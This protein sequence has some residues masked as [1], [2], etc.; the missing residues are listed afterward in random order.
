MNS[1]PIPTCNRILL[2][3]AP[4]ADSGLLLQLVARLA[5]PRAVWVMVPAG[6][7]TDAV[8]ARLSDLLQDGDELFITQS[9]LVLEQVI[10]KYLFNTG[11]SDEEK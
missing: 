3:A 1:F 8:I 11:K 6:E 5:P 4:S 10:G 2:V 9:A 7:A